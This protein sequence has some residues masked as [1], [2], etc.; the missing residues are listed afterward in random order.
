MPG[1]DS[2]VLQIDVSQ[3]LRS[4][5]ADDFQAR[6]RDYSPAWR[7]IIAAFR[8]QVVG[9]L[10]GRY[11]LTPQGRKEAW[12][13]PHA[14][15]RR[16]AKNPVFGS[17]YLAAWRGGSGGI[18]DVGPQ[19]ARVGVQGF[20]RLSLHRGGLGPLTVREYRRRDG[21]AARISYEAQETPWKLAKGA[22]HRTGARRYALWWKILREHGVALKDETLRRGL[23]I[24]LRPHA[25]I[26]PGIRT[27][28]TAVLT[29]AT[30]GRSLPAPPKS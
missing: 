17:D 23:R 21:T 18:E 16:P 2:Q 12:P 5:W 22:E 4:T 13:A 14:F 6:I 15:G 3:L 20:E 1:R 25:S 7:I 19:E 30:L 8:D 27:Y 28:A 9:E 10:R 11:W 29:A 24:P 26:G